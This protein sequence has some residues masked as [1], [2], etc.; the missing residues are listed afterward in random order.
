MFHFWTDTE[1]SK[2]IQTLETQNEN[3]RYHEQ[4]AWYEMLCL[5]IALVSLAFSLASLFTLFSCTNFWL[6]IN[7]MAANSFSV[8]QF[9][10]VLGI[11]I[12]MALVTVYLFYFLA[13]GGSF[14]RVVWRKSGKLSSQHTRLLHKLLLPLCLLIAVA[15][16]GW[17]VSHVPILSLTQRL[18]QTTLPIVFIIFHGLFCLCFFPLLT[19]WVRL[20]TWLAVVKKSSSLDVHACQVNNEND[21]TDRDDDDHDHDHGMDNSENTDQPQSNDLEKTGSPSPQTPRHDLHDSPASLSAEERTKENM[22]QSCP[23][24]SATTPLPPVKPETKRIGVSIYHVRLF[25]YY[26]TTVVMI[27]FLLFFFTVPLW[28]DSAHILTCSVGRGVPLK[29]KLIAHR[30]LIAKAPENSL[31]AM[32]AALKSEAIWAIESDIFFSQDCVPFAMHDQTFIRTTNVKTVFPSRAKEP[33]DQYL[34]SDIQKLECGSWFSSEFAGE[35]IPTLE[36]ILLSLKQYPDKRFIFDLRL[37]D[38]DHPC[39]H[40]ANASLTHLFKSTGTGHQII[41]LDLNESIR[42]EFPTAYHAIGV[43]HETERPSTSQLL[44]SKYMMINAE[45]TLPNSYLRNMTRSHHWTNMYHVNEPW[46]FSQTWC[47]GLKSVTSNHPELLYQ[48]QTPIYYFSKEQY[49]NLCMALTLASILSI[50]VWILALKMAR[51]L[52]HHS[53]LCKMMQRRN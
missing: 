42:E 18:G 43:N 14:R 2:R 26:A 12:L 4:L 8:S 35:K 48:M 46:L 31:A 47:L 50:F 39:Y 25:M 7:Q 24:A 11:S 23:E 22:P 21:D 45:P 52:K 29:P 32:D 10:F 49:R 38:K 1:S 20:Y 30:G 27:G 44:T 41:Y 6:E 28:L 17:L 37:P 51:M 53:Q 36:S 13:R 15:V 40:T 9:N 16:F 34:W 3:L 5:S 33:V 19:Y